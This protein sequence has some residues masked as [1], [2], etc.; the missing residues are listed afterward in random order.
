MAERGLTVLVVEDESSL[1]A[2]VERMLELGGHRAILCASG[3]EAIDIVTAR[4]E[5]FDVLLSDVV[6]DGIDGVA[7]AEEVCRRRP[8]TPIVMMSGNHEREVTDRLPA[9]CPSRF[10]PK[11]YNRQV[12]V[13][14]VEAA[15]R[16][17]DHPGA[18][19]DRLR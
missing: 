11:P 12:L 5:A 2:M 1:R 19:G 9:G 4:R 10:V 3:E 16:D 7:V 6:L 17:A 18:R 14:A 15:W 13:D 8:G